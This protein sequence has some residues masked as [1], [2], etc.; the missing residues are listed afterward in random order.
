MEIM[1]AADVDAWLR[2]GG[3][4]VTASERAARALLAAF[5]RARRAEGLASWPAPAIQ[6]WNELVRS[7]WQ[8]RALDG[9]LILNPVQEESL[10]AEVIAA[11]AQAEIPLEGPRHRAA[12]LAMDA[13]ALLCAYAPELLQPRLRIAW[14]QDAAAFSGWLAAFDEACRAGNLISASRL[15]LEL[16]PLLETPSAED[17]A[18]SRPA[19]LLAGF[20]RI[21][22]V[23][24]RVF[25]AWGSWRNSAPPELTTSASGTRDEQPSRVH[26]YQARDS[27]SEL[28]A[29]AIWCSRRLAAN[30]AERLLVVSHEAAAR[31]GEMERAFLR[32]LGSETLFEFTLGIPMDQVP[33]IHCAHLLLRWLVAPLAEHEVDWLFASGYAAGALESSALQAAMRAFRCRNL[34]QPDWPLDAFLAQCRALKPDAI[35]AAAAWL[36]RLSQARQRVADFFRQPHSHFE[37]AEFASQLLESLGWPATRSLSSTQFQAARRFQHALETAASLGFNGHRISWQDFLASV[38]RIL[39]ETL[40][41]PESRDAPVQIAGPAESAGLSADAIWFLGACEDAWPPAAKSH[42]LL[43]IQVQRQFSMPHASPQDDWD[44]AYAITKRLLA[45]ALEI[46]FSF[47]Q[48]VEGVES[49]SSR[50]VEQFAGAAQPLPPE[51]TLPSVPAPL[52]VYFEDTSLVPYPPGKVEGGATV[53]TFQSQCPFKAFAAVRLAAQTWNPAQPSLTP[54]QRGKLLHA[55]MHAIWAGPLDGLR[56]LQ[57]LENLGDRSCFIAAHIRRAFQREIRSHLRARMP[58]AYL[59]IEEQRLLRLVSEWLDYESKRVNFEVLKTE[60]ERTIHLA[61]LTFDLRLDRIDRLNDG[62][63]LVIDYKTGEVTPKAWDLPRPDDVQLPLYAAFALDTES[64]ELGGLTFARVQPGKICFSG[65][66][67]DAHATLISSLTSR[68]TLVRE[69]FSA[70]MLIGWRERIEQLARDFLTGRAQ[71]DPREYPKTCER[72]DLQSLCR[73]HENQARCEEEN[74]TDPEFAEG[75]DE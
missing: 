30:P 52:T 49:R 36:D 13:H 16:I 61:G 34:E 38:A 37:C 20:D 68:D 50:L 72:C 54:A 22:P 64:E 15:P 57:D 74:G 24:R 3:L 1:A 62:T 44:L 26:F 66:I 21:Q 71:V 63:L 67:G 51:L 60:D 33:L 39:N 23:Q 41:A 19:L 6:P 73:I 40:F 4:V 27:Q 69:P 53:L 18:S 35:S 65:R 70:E 12:R 9:R 11:E 48:H 32:H 55:V 29:C 56:N 2:S 75:A 59:E 42:P 31:R 25:E 8:Q 10:W 45:S 7:A 5:H 46:H 17:N 47:A 58:R 14:Q 28:A 43:P